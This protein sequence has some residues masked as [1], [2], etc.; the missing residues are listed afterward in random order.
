MTLRIVLRSCSKISRLAALTA[1]PLS[2]RTLHAALESLGRPGY[3]VVLVHSSLSAC[4]YIPGG[5]L[6]VIEALRTWCEGATL[7]M[8]THTYCYP[9]AEGLSKTFDPKSTPSVVGAIGDMFWRQPS[10]VR[11]LHPTHSLAAVGPMAATVIAG[12][13]LCTTPCG[14]GTPYHRLVEWDAGVLMFGVTFDSYT[15]F[16]TAEDAAEV[17][18]LYERNPYLL[19]VREPDG[20]VRKFSLRRH[21]MKVRR[22]FGEMDQWLERRGLSQRRRCGRGEI[23]WVPQAAAAHVALCDTL[24]D[25]P[26]FLTKASERHRGTQHVEGTPDCVLRSPR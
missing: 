13:D 18:Y 5:A 7:V 20:G 2:K 10:V 14:V 17:P 15:L 12:H 19:Q 26:W 3:R 21:D 9:D 22:R 16:H 25:D 24:K 1:H 8:P 23:R 6:T 4:G 11:S